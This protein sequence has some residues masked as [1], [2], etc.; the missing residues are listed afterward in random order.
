MN[1][2]QI[3]IQTQEPSTLAQNL[4][5]AAFEEAFCCAFGCDKK[6]KCCKKYKT[7]GKHC[8]KCPKI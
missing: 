8:K 4:C 7:K 2:L 3:Q 6:D 1:V 5:T